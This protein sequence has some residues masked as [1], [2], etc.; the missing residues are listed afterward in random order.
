MT[1]THFVL[2]SISLPIAAH[3]QEPSS[4]L[5]TGLSVLTSV[6]FQSAKA[7]DGI[8]QISK[9]LYENLLGRYQQL[10]EPDFNLFLDGGIAQSLAGENQ[11]FLHGGAGLQLSRYFVK[12]FYE[13]GMMRHN[14]TSRVGTHLEV[15]FDLAGGF[16]LGA[17]GGFFLETTQERHMRSSRSTFSGNHLGAVARYEL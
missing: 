16:S 4:T 15:K 10:K 3:A 13:H 7:R 9:G 12:L 11:A 2:V 1:P 17:F 8:K 14:M 5:T 6:A